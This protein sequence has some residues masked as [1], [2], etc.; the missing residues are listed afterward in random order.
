MPSTPS[1]FSLSSVVH[2][3]WLRSIFAFRFVL[4]MVLFT[5]I[6]GLFLHVTERFGGLSWGLSEWAHVMVGWVAVPWTT[7]YLVHHLVKKWGSFSDAFRLMGLLLA[8]S[9]VLTLLSGLFLDSVPGAADWPGLL[10]L[11]Y[12]LTFPI[13][14]LLVLHP[15]RILRGRLSGWMRASRWANRREQ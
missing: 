11:H 4:M 10:D 9:L 14:V 8:L 12:F 13:L 1:R 5:A 7:G 6:S 2:S 15:S 3:S